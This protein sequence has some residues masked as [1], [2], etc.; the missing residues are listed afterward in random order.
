MIWAEKIDA[1]SRADWLEGR[2]KKDKSDLKLQFFFFLLALFYP[3]IFKEW[4]WINTLLA[5]GFL[6]AA[7]FTA[8]SVIDSEGAREKYLKSRDVEAYASSNLRLFCLGPGLK[9]QSTFLLSSFRFAETDYGFGSS[10]LGRAYITLQPVK[11]PF[12]QRVELFFLNNFTFV[13]GLLSRQIYE[14]SR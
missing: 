2:L 1:E 4:N 5:I 10:K 7:C 8:V 9:I 12:G 13:A 14:N 11:R 3:F 6:L